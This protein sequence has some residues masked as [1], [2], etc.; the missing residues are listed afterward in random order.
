MMLE[1]EKNKDIDQKRM[2]TK[3]QNENKAQR[4]PSS[5]VMG[6]QEVRMG[7][8]CGIRSWAPWEAAGLVMK[9]LQLAWRAAC[10]SPFQKNEEPGALAS[11]SLPQEKFGNKE[12][13]LTKSGLRKP[14]HFSRAGSIL[15]F[16]RM[17]KSLTQPRVGRVGWWGRDQIAHPLPHGESPVT[18]Y[19]EMW[20]VY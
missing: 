11:L 1:K 16:W 18:I 5:W 12:K 4:C 2:W 14:Y 3:V 15:L 13:F 17:G 6:P 9:S 7:W 19:L 8:L 10:K 20:K